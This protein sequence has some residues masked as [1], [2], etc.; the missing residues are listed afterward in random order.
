LESPPKIIEVFPGRRDADDNLSIG[1]GDNLLSNHVQGTSDAKV[2]FK[3]VDPSGM[4]DA[5]YVVKFD[6]IVVD[7][8][9]GEKSLAYSV[10]RQIAN[11]TTVDTVISNSTDFSPD[12]ENKKIIDGLMVI[13]NNYGLDSLNAVPTAYRVRDIIE[14]RNTQGVDLD[15]PVNVFYDIDTNAIAPDGNWYIKS[16]DN[17]GLIWQKTALK[18]GLKYNYYEIRFTGTSQYY[19]TSKLFSDKP[20]KNNELGKGTLPFEIWDIGRT[21]DDP[22][23]DKRLIIKIL[24]KSLTEGEAV[25]D[26]Q[27]TQLPNGDWEQIYAYTDPDLNPDSLESTSGTSK[28][29]D[30][31]FGRLVFHGDIPQ[32]GS[33]VVI[34]IRTYMGLNDEDQFAYNSSVQNFSDPTVAKNNLDKITVFPNPYFGANSLE[35]NKYVRFVRFT[36][37]P[38]HAIIRIFSLSGV[39]IKKLEKDDLSQYLDWNLHNKDELPVASGV[40]IAHIDMPGIGTKILK[41]AIIQ[42]QQ[43]IDRL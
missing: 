31:K 10:E 26:S 15:P 33:G 36:G 11:N 2:E 43:Y 38:K 7:T 41:L 35:T 29:E 32:A 24:D 27:W 37:L 20:T 3:V 34:R 13:V 39:F 40:Y 17:K 19:T 5:Q 42:E 23:D 4:I 8:S 14:A 16:A 1:L 28:Q 25:E 6:T 12:D 18:Q 21:I 30:H 22:S 9:T